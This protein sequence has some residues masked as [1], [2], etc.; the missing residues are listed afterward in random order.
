VLSDYAQTTAA[1]T[2]MS[3]RDSTATNDVAVLKGSR[4]V[5]ANETAQ[6]KRLDEA[7]IK[8][9]TG[10]DTISARRLYKEFS[11]FKPEFKLWLRTNHKPVV[12]DTDEGIWD[13]LKLIPFAVRITK[14]EQDTH[15][16]EK[17][18]SEQSG[19]LAWAVEGCLEWQRDGLGVP[20]E[21]ESATAKYREEQDNFANFI[22]ECCIVADN[23]WTPTAELR[24][25]YDVWCKERG[26][27]PSVTGNAFTERLHALN[28][29][30]KSG[31]HAGNVVRG[32]QGIGLELSPQ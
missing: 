31:R 14:H 22:S 10:G 25:A 16:A 3:K 4:F 32:W 26:E 13:R 7:G 2:L 20:Q 5:F 17:L 15:L 24:N 12:H 30:V 29:L 18:R 19:I 1:S 21:V 9:I 6:N 8:N 23:A 11:N 28:C 27:R